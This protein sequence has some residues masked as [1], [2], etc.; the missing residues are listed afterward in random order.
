ML[1]GITRHNGCTCLGDES[2][3]CLFHNGCTRFR[4]ESPTCF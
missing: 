1:K 2:P 4:D 3:T